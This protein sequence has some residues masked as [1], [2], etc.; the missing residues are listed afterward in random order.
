M[1]ACKFLNYKF[2]HHHV[3][4]EY[5]PW[6]APLSL[7]KLIERSKE[8]G[9][10]TVTVTDHGTVGSWVKLAYQC[11]DAGVKPIFGIEAYFTQNRNARTARSDNH[12]LVLLAKNREGIRNIFRLSQLAYS[13]GFYYDPRVDWE[14]LEKYHEGIVC[15]S[16]CVSGL[17]LQLLLLF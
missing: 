12:H 16:G 15:T 7:K 3:H 13:D 2:A 10:R 4:T 17:C 11:K 9:Y 8:L 14:L 1:N 5:S 6:D